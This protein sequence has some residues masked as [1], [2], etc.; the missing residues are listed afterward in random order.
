MPYRAV[1][2]RAVLEPSVFPKTPDK[3]T[4]SLAKNEKKKKKKDASLLA[5][6]APLAPCFMQ[7]EYVLV[8]VAFMLPC[9]ARAAA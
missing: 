3:T 1:P 8:L 2:C 9:L 7:T 5:S 4:A 6:L